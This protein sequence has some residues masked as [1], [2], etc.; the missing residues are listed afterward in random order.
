MYTGTTDVC[1]V[2]KPLPVGL[3]Q[4]RGVEIPQ[5]AIFSTKFT[6]LN[7]TYGCSMR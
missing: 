5:H 6:A 7:D 1:I 4:D 2:T 3:L